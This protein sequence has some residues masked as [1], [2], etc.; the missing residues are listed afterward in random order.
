VVTRSP[1]EQDRRAFDMKKPGGATRHR[2]FKTPA[3]ASSEN[4]EHDRADKGKGDIRGDHTQ[5]VG[6]CHG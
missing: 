6:H 4:A 2:A 1:P 3:A 5:P